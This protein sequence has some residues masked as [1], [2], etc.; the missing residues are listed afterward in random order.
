MT[1]IG[2]NRPGIQ[3]YSSVGIVFD[4]D[5]TMLVADYSNNRIVEW[6][7]NST[8]GE[9]VL[10]QDENQLKHPVD[11]IIDQN[12]NSLI[13]ADQGNRRVI[14]WSREN[15]EDLEILITDIDCFGLAIWISME[16]SM[17]LITEKMK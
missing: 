7:S 9:I 16:I 13:I 15:H 3:L 11:M 5:Q 2:K 17:L 14:R 6:K 12:D 4:N 1:I 10:G 8:N